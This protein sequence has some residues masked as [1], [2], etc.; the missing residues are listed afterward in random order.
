MHLNNQRLVRREMSMIVLERWKYIVA[1]TARRL[2]RMTVWTWKVLLGLPF[3]DKN[4]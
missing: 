3:I 2:Q 4:I 1:E